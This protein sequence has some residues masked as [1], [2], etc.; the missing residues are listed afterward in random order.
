VQPVE[1]SPR[2]CRLVE[3]PTY[4]QADE[5]ALF[6]HR[7]EMCGV[8]LQ[9]DYWKTEERL[10]KLNIDETIVVYGST[11][12]IDLHLARR[13][14]G[15]SQRALAAHSDMQAGQHAVRVA[16]RRH[17]ATVRSGIA[18]GPN[19]SNRRR[20]SSL[21]RPASSCASIAA[22]SASGNAL[23]TAHPRAGCR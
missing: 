11:R 14:F 13:R 5:D 22:S 17:R 20:A 2:V 12:I 3:S 16:A 1:L 6:L 18:F 23:M 8:R 4:L 9:L 19:C 10:Q 21:V 15:D 7:R